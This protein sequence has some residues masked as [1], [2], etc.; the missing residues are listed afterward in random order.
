MA[1]LC[2]T[3]L[4]H[5]SNPSGW[6]EKYAQFLSA[7]ELPEYKEMLRFIDLSEEPFEKRVYKSLQ[8]FLSLHGPKAAA[9]LMWYL[10]TARNI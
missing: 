9:Y 7:V 5:E 1:L 3:Y 6:K 2:R 10:S 4:F 8:C